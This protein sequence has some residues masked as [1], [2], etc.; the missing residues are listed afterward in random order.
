MNQTATMALVRA[1]L[2]AVEPKQA[3]HAFVHRHGD[4]LFVDNQEYDLK[5]YKRL[6]VVGGGK[7]GAPM[8][9]A[10]GE[11][12]GDRLTTGR[13]NVKRGY[14]IDTPLPSALTLCEAGHP[15]PDQDG[16]QSTAHMLELVRQ[17]GQDDLIFCLISGGGSALMP[18]PVPGISLTDL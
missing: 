9:Q 15:I 13:I 12:L 18:A 3:V 6:F 11:I 7:A 4:L 16:Q 5:R 17:A 10:L 8:A 14:V 1:A 2:D